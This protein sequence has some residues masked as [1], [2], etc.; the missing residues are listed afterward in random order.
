M[1]IWRTLY[2]P[3]KTLGP[4]NFYSAG[5]YLCV[6]GVCLIPSER[7]EKSNPPEFADEREAYR[8]YRA[9]SGLVHQFETLMAE[10][11]RFITDSTVQKLPS[12]QSIRA[13]HD[14]KQE[15][16]VIAALTF[17]EWYSLCHSCFTQYRSSDISWQSEVKVGS[18]S[19]WSSGRQFVDA[20][21]IAWAVPDPD[22]NP[23]LS[24]GYWHHKRLGMPAEM[25]MSGISIFYMMYNS[26]DV[27]DSTFIVRK[28]TYFQ[29]W[30]SQANHIFTQ[31]EI[32]SNY[33]DYVYW[34]LDPQGRT[35]L[36]VEEASNLGF[37][38][39]EVK[40][41]VIV[42]SWG[43]N[44]Y[45]ALRKGFRSGQSRCLSCQKASGTI[46]PEGKWNY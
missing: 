25:D 4:T 10:Q 42:Q 39:L 32:S 27:F 23:Q 17:H 24:F 7:Y 44:I 28:S 26:C 14:L 22:T 11:M 15:S 35:R 43:D 46:E 41:S 38:S 30:L 3:Q 21:E 19:R 37:P 31:L 36:S 29:W 20:V 5:L 2:A 45:A 6:H 34:S 33:D 16:C 1:W 12:L 8:Y 9:E 13:L 18:I 40:T